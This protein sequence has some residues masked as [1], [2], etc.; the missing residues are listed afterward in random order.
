M[1]RQMQ[2]LLPA[3]TDLYRGVSG[4]GDFLLPLSML[5]RRMGKLWAGGNGSLCHV[6]QCFVEIR[7]ALS[8][9]WKGVVFAD[10]NHILHELCKLTQLF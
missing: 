10:D 8:Q 2:F 6:T 5:K 7:S 3:F 4:E 9:F 1:H